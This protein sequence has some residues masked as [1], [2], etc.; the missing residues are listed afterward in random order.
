ML[1]SKA[2]HTPPVMPPPMM[3]QKEDYKCVVWVIVTELGTAVSIPQIKSKAE[4]DVQMG[5]KVEIVP[6]PSL[7]V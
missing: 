2:S 5:L 7:D 1:Q 6:L 3:D 4:N